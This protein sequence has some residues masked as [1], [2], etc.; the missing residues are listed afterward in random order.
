MLAMYFKFKVVF[1]GN[2]KLSASILRENYQNFPNVNRSRSAIACSV[3][4]PHLL[5]L[6]NR[7]KLRIWV[8]L[9]KM[10]VLEDYLESHTDWLP[11][12]CPSDLSGVLQGQTPNCWCDVFLWKQNISPIDCDQRI[13]YHFKRGE[14]MSFLKNFKNHAIFKSLFLTPP[15]KSWQQL[16]RKYLVKYR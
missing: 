5:K 12:F 8:T 9:I 13:E 4:R 14:H 16:V 1:G 3:L 10:L 2:T 6:L 11:Q 7:Q 15:P